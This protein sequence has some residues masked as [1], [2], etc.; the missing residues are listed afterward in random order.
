ME[1]EIPPP[2]IPLDMLYHLQNQ[3]SYST[4][5]FKKHL[6]KKIKNDKHENLNFKVQKHLNIRFF[7]SGRILY[8]KKTI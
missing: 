6:N 1:L 2:K 3:L 8:G 7:L 4:E 5:G